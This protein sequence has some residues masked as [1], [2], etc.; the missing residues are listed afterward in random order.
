MLDVLQITLGIVLVTIIILQ[1]KGTGLGAAFGGGSAY[2]T[3]RGA[4]K[5]L[6]L[7]TIVTSIIFFLVAIF[8]TLVK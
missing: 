1:A 4:E 3:K 6:F 8:N 5:F 7:A 2:H